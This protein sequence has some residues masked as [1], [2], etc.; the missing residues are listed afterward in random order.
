MVTDGHVQNCRGGLDASGSHDDTILTTI[1]LRLR[2]WHAEV[3]ERLIRVISILLT[4]NLVAWIAAITVDR[5]AYKCGKSRR[6]QEWP[7]VARAARTRI[8]ETRTCWMKI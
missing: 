4:V 7:L 1:C 2:Q 5:V 6:V 8:H 3:Q